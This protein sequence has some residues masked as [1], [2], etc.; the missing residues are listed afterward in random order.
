MPQDHVQ[1]HID[2]IAR[3]EEEFLSQR[4]RLERAGDK[5]A[6]LVGSMRFVGVHLTLFFGW[7]GWNLVSWLPH[8]DPPPFSLLATLLAMEGIVLASV[9]LMRQ[10]RMS[11][12]ADERDHLML[13]ILMLTE[14]ELTALLKMDRQIAHKVGLADAA[15]SA[16]IRELSEHTS[17]DDVAQTIRESLSADE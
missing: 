7:I 16:E 10:A 9:I 11:R 12:R 2:L 13:Q 14:K 3:H 8:F 15:Q 17:I 5:L 1:E 4:T 6:G